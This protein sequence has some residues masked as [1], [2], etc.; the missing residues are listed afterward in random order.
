MDRACRGGT[1]GRLFLRHLQRQR[2]AALAPFAGQLLAVSGRRRGIRAHHR[3]DIHHD[4]AAVAALELGRDAHRA[5]VGRIERGRGFPVLRDEVHDDGERTARD[6]EHAIPVAVE[7]QCLLSVRR[8]GDRE[9]DPE[10]GDQVGEAFHG[11]YSFWKISSMRSPKTSAMAKAKGSDG[12]YL[13]FSMAFTELRD[14][15]SR[16]AR[17]AWVQPRSALSTRMRFFISRLSAWLGASRP[18]TPGNR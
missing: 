8:A 18:S 5:L 16:L 4:L 11:D 17:S 13:P 9:C 3:C 1:A 12:S 6:D 15:S 2:L 14:T 7:L 10:G